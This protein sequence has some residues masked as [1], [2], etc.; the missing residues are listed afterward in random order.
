MAPKF[1]IQLLR[2]QNDRNAFPIIDE[3][4]FEEE[5]VFT[6]NTFLGTT[7]DIKVQYVKRLV[8]AFE[9]IE[10]ELY[11]WWQQ[12]LDIGDDGNIYVSG[13]NFEYQQVGAFKHSG[14]SNLVILASDYIE[15]T[16]DLG[17][18]D[19]VGLIDGVYFESVSMLPSSIVRCFDFTVVVDEVWGID[20][21]VNYPE[22][23]YTNYLIVG[24]KRD[25][26]NQYWTV[27]V[28]KID[29]CEAGLCGDLTYD[30]PYAVEAYDNGTIILNYDYYDYVADQR[31]IVV[32]RS[33]DYGVT[34]GE[35]IVIV[36]GRGTSY[37]KKGDDGYLYISSYQSQTAKIFKSEDLGL[38]W[39]EINLPNLL[40]APTENAWGYMDFSVDA[41]G[42]IY[43]VI[44][45]WTF[46]SLYTS[47][48]GG[49]NW[50]RYDHNAIT[51]PL[52]I[53]ANTTAIVV[54]GGDS[55]G[56]SP[57]HYLLLRS[58]DGGVNFTEVFDLYD[59]YGSSIAYQT[60]K[61]NGTIFAFTECAMTHVP[62]DENGWL[63]WLVSYDNGL[64]WTEEYAEN[65]MSVMSG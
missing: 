22:W 18:F 52:F 61:H 50:N 58:T 25:D 38:T 35:E 36:T 32:I 17:Y 27:A 48:D 12:S 55:L 11:Y 49:S 45:R 53:T 62:H 20:D 6:R 23:R 3:E 31:K 19:Y 21:P 10:I 60:L 59:N 8:E 43:A 29:D 54:H 30:S 34:W 39:S 1:A 5:P 14:T 15:D 57:Y 44:P 26:G 65:V 42:K 24:V 47:S 51:R 40:A 64:T 16:E 9:T 2:G 56:G 13:S 37:I 41:N 4:D 28:N 33:T 63:A 7:N 46:F